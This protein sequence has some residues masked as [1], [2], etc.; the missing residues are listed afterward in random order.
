MC[1]E[2]LEP[3]LKPNRKAKRAKKLGQ[4]KMDNEERYESV[5]QG[6]V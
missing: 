4:P 5:D 1:E 6:K 3:T 2:R